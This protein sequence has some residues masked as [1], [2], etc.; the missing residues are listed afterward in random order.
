M[1]KKLALLPALFALLSIPAVLCGA[2][3]W[4][5]QENPILSPWAEQVSPANAHPEYPRPQFVRNDWVNLNGLWDYAIIKAG[6][7]V[8]K[9]DGK[10]L[11]PY[12]VESA[13][14]GVKREVGKDNLLVYRRTVTIPAGW[15]DKNVILNFEACDW[16]TDVNVNGKHVGTHIGGYAPFSFDITSALKPEGE[17]E[18]E[19][20]V[21]DPTSDHWQPRGKQVTNPHGIWYTPVTG[22][23]ATVWMEPVAKQGQL[24]NCAG[25][26]AKVV[27]GKLVP[28]NGGNMFIQGTAK[29]ADPKATVF[30]E[31][32][33]IDPETGVTLYSGG[34][35]VKDGK[36]RMAGKVKDVKFWSPES[37]F[38]Y[39]VKYR[40]SVNQRTVDTV[41]SYL[42]MRTSTLGKTA[43]GITR[44]MINGK[45]IFQYGPLD[46]GWWPDG[47]YAAPTDEA[48]K[49][50]LIMTQ[51][52]GFNMLRKHVKVEPRRF[53]YHCDKMGLLV[54]QDM[55]NGDRHISPRDP[56]IVRSKESTEN[57]YREWS[58]IMDTLQNSPSIV[59]WVP[60]NEGWGQFDT[61][62]VLDW[63]KAKDPT[64]L[65]DGPSGWS[66]RGCGDVH[67]MHRYPGPGMFPPE[68]NRATVLGEFGGL[69]LPC[70][71]NAWK[72]QG[73][74][75]Y[76]SF[77][78]TE[79]L[80]A[81]YQN[82][83]VA[84]RKL[85]DKGLSAAVYTQTTDVEIEVNGL[86]SYDRKVDKMGWENVAKI[87][88]RL[89]KPL[90]VEKEVVKCGQEWSYT[91]DAPAEN[92][93]NCDFDASAWKVG[94]NLGANFPPNVNIETKWDTPE[95]WVRRTFELGDVA[96]KE[97][98]L[99]L[100]HDE[101]AT[102]YVNGVK[103]LETKGYTAEYTT[104]ELPAE[105]MKAFKAGKN[106][107]AIHCRQTKGGQFIDCGIVSLEE[108]K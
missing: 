77:A 20:V 28:C 12:P 13:L 30:V 36:F 98:A 49:Y 105:A 19:V 76:V 73:N 83:I 22:M 55:P 50:D 43:D 4:K 10:I 48:L 1:T 64:R 6:E 37:P 34:A 79:G 26:A 7:H 78:D 5:I 40:L 2:A 92:W 99:K 90:P 106:T 107:I 27:D 45:F 71:D 44:M 17:Q 35:M 74:W 52:M 25:Y 61:Q 68:E 101:D 42:G 100:Y 53:Y 8:Q 14:S 94:K 11:V 65:V 108:A 39:T 9:W 18:I 103:V 58:E 70:P 15:K 97:F 102:V 69:G 59:M 81:K 33:V 60:F 66:D 72:K 51:K 63:T 21:F 62:T 57:Y 31:A 32:D 41:E 82:L 75:G 56:D 54:W 104:Y 24:L 3:E 95:I 84:L 80:R 46:Q 23:W 96:G 88:S 47:L 89:Y 38:L 87:N 85:I 29:V 67:D 91:T 16:K 86:M 93:M